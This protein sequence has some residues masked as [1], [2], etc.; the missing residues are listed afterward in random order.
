MLI[1][2]IFMYE[3]KRYQDFTLNLKANCH[4]SVHSLKQALKSLTVFIFNKLL[5]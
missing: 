1:E 2:L 5:K 3:E 4:F